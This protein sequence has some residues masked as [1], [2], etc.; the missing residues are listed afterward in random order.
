MELVA[1]SCQA[2]ICPDAATGGLAET[3]IHMVAGSC[4]VARGALHSHVGAHPRRHR[5]NLTC[6]W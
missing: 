3:R 5:L 2:V 6:G 1:A 4:C